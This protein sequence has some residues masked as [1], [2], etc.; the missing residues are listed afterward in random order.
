[1][2]F[3]ATDLSESYHEDDTRAPRNENVQKY[4]DETLAYKMI[5]VSHADIDSLMLQAIVATR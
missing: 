1:M 2:C 5:L 4:I 3:I